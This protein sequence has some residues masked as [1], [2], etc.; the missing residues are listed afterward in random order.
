M[1]VYIWYTTI[2]KEPQ[3]YRKEYETLLFT[4]GK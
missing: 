2:L 4:Y 3:I 1:W